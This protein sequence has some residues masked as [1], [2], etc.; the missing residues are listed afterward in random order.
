MIF[1]WFKYVLE[2][3]I[4]PMNDILAAGTTAGVKLTLYS[5]RQTLYSLRQITQ[6]YVDF[7]QLYIN[8]NLRMI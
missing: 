3:T 1:N 8:A 4:L 7:I 2:F 5:L 6:P